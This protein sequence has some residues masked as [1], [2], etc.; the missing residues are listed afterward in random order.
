M[1]TGSGGSWRRS[2]AVS[3]RSSVLGPEFFGDALPS[4]GDSPDESPEVDF[5]G[6]IEIGSLE[7]TGGRASAGLE[8]IAAVLD[9]VAMRAELVGG[10]ADASIEAERLVVGRLGRDLL[11]GPLSLE[12]EASSAGV[13]VRS[14]EIKGDAAR[15]S[16]TGRLT[17]SPGMSGRFE[18]ELE[19]DLQEVSEWWDPNLV[20]GLAPQGRV[21]L[22][23]FVELD[24]NGVFTAEFDHRGAPLGLAGY[25]FDTLELSYNGGQPAVRVEGA[26]WGRAEVS[27]DASGATSVSADLDRAPVDRLLAFSFPQV[28][29]ALKGPTTITGRLDGTFSFPVDP[30]TLVGD[31]DLVVAW[32]DG[33]IAVRGA[34]VGTEW[35]ITRMEAQLAGVTAS[36]RRRRRRRWASV[37][38]GRAVG[39]RSRSDGGDSS[40]PGPPIWRTWASA[41]GRSRGR[42]GW[43]DR[44]TTRSWR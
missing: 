23:G 34:G 18:S 32:S 26:G 5:W 39:G 2:R 17:L 14:L 4:P 35:S 10:V 3:R 12:V 21:R 9:G 25:D 11:L 30:A 37:G 28:A 42:C 1:P 22:V 36:R 15:L 13:D 19:A 31:V 24:G 8:D 27:L 41:A 16:T 29:E 33:R 38:R 44:W 7:I 43:T 20:T 6:V 40:S